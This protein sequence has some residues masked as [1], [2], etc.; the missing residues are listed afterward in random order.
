MFGTGQQATEDGLTLVRTRGEIN[1]AIDTGGALL[2]GWTRMAFGICMVSENAFTVGVMAIP[3]P[4]T[5]IEWDGWIWHWVGLLFTVATAP[6]DAAGCSVV[7]I[8]IDSKAMRKWKAPDALVAMG[9]V[10]GEVGTVQSQ[11]NLN[12]RILMKLP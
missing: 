5:D 12:T 10:S 1:V 11:A 3:H 4:L 9:E 7:W 8:P 2:D 6:V